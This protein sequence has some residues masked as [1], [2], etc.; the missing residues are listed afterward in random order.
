MNMLIDILERVFCYKFVKN[1][2][3]LQCDEDTV[4]LVD[5]LVDFVYKLDGYQ[6]I[7]RLEYEFV[8]HVFI[9]AHCPTLS[10]ESCSLWASFMYETGI[11]QIDFK[12]RYVEYIN[13]LNETDTKDDDEEIT[14]MGNITSNEGDGEIELERL[15]NAVRGLQLQDKLDN[16]E[17]DA[18]DSMSYVI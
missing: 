3:I 12:A 9:H 10:A 17:G 11:R 14:Y 2:S 13:S 16:K 18:L 1:G 8:A 15:V 7:Y 6:D 4:F 5:R